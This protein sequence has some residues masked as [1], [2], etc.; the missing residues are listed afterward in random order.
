MNELSKIQVQEKIEPERAQFKRLLLQNPN[1]F[2]NFTNSKYKPVKKIIGN[3]SYEELTCIGFNPDLQI[4]EATIVIKR[5]L[6]YA[7]SLC[8][9]GSFEFVRFFVDY[10]GGWVDEGVVSVN[11]HD[12]PDEKDCAHQ[13]NKPLTYVLTLQIDPKKLRC[14]YPFLPKVHAV[15]SWNVLP[16]ITVGVPPV[17]GNSLECNIQIKPRKPI[18]LDVFEDAKLKLSPEY[19]VVGDIPI[20]IPDPPP[21]TLSELAELYQGK[22]GDENKA[23]QG[24][25]AKVESHRFGFAALKSILASNTFDEET[26]TNNISVWKAIGID[27]Q[28]ALSLLKQT[29]ANVDYEE[30]ECLGLDYDKE[31]LVASFR[32][33]R[34][35]GYLG[36]LCKVGSFE[37]VAFWA[38]WNNECQWTYLGTVSVKVHDLEDKV[39]TGGVCYCA[40]LPVSLDGIRGKCKD[41]KVARIRAVLSWNQT[42]STVDPDDLTYW[43]NRLD[44]HVQIKPGAVLPPDVHRPIIFKVGDVIP[45]KINQTNGLAT[46]HMES[47]GSYLEESPFG[48]TIYIN[49]KLAHPIPYL[50]GSPKLKYRISVRKEGG[51]WQVL[52]NSFKVTVYD[53]IGSTWFG[54]TTINQV[55][56]DGWFDYLEDIENI[57]HMRFVVDDKLAIWN[58]AGL[59]DGKWEIMIEAKDELSGYWTAD[60]YNCPVC[61]DPIDCPF[62]GQLISNV[63]VCLDNTYPKGKIKIDFL[64]DSDFIISG[65]TVSTTP[66]TACGDF[67]LGKYIIGRFSVTDDSPPTVPN[68]PHFRQYRLKV[69]PTDIDGVPTPQNFMHVPSSTSWPSIPTSGFSLPPIPYPSPLPSGIWQL[70]TSGFKK[71]GYVVFLEGEDRTNWNSAGYT[72]WIGLDHIGFCLKEPGKS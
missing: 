10:G 33:K 43:G 31:R 34:P 17:W 67:T 24:K 36:N 20:P 7:G 60:P 11:V 62:P 23:F 30:I 37:H 19:E 47:H 64:S 14:S 52:N 29:K 68:Q 35:Y 3:T 12:I 71:C 65:G 44:T 40:I 72:G 61:A 69:Y 18:I 9:A 25:E 57:G 32:I 15:L 6:G 27:I 22:L 63:I 66:G 28:A 21:L 39:P 13:N 46:G 49:G 53:L 48:G 16:P 56:P 55:A 4:L 42:P 41:P 38:D 26:V 70:N 50:P 1:Y 58:T 5:P 59:E 2:G 51:S 54:P 8:Y 45:C